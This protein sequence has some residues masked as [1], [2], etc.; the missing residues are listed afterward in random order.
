MRSKNRIRFSYTVSFLLVSLLTL[1]ET[2]YCV[3]SNLYPHLLVDRKSS[4]AVRNQPHFWPPGNPFLAVR[5]AGQMVPQ[6]SGPPLP[7]SPPSVAAVP[8][9]ISS[10]NRRDQ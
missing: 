2:S 4:R 9:L 6:A 1:D 5:S 3:L 7:F 8:F 10:L